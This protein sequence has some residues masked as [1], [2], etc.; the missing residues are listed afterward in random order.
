MDDITKLE[1]QLKKEFGFIKEEIRFVVRH[2]PSFLLWQETQKTGMNTLRDFFVKKYGF[3]MELV[4]T[5]V[6]KYPFILSKTQDQLDNVFSTLEKQGVSHL[7]SIKLIFECPKLVSVDLEKSISETLSL[8]ELYHKIKQQEVMDIFR[9]FPYLFCCDTVK[10]RT[11]LS[12]F[13][14]YR[15]TNDQILNLVSFE[16]AFLRLILVQ[17]FEW[18]ACKQSFQLLRILR[19]FET[20]S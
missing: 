7:E 12:Q 9:H 3:D 8:F 13:R 4:H 11:L 14:K 5:L 2:K 17:T 18:R 15:F 16:A 19:L 1:S 20:P 6:V 10:M